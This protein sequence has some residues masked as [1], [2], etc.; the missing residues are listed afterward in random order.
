LE[1]IDERKAHIKAK[2][3]DAI[4][5]SFL[6]DMM[7]RAELAYPSTFADVL[8]DNTTLP[9]HK[10]AKLRQIRCFRMEYEMAQ[11]AKAS[12]LSFTAK[13]LP[14]NDW[15]YTYVVT[16]SFGLTQAYVQQMGLLPNPAKY[17][18][19][20]ANAARIPRLALDDDAAIYES[21]NFYGLIAHNPIGQIF[22]E[23]KQK[24]GSMQLCVPFEGMK[25]WALEIPLPELLS[26]YP[27]V[28]K[29]PIATPEPTW[30]KA[31]IKKASGEK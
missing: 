13:S 19:N 22:E 29:E 3:V 18:E 8:H 23:S 14:E 5:K 12:G 11:A 31:G 15:N 21:R 10:L 9:E 30:K 27:I 26:L 7:R 25:G 16:G 28:T 24:L 2:A 4:P 17:R 20:L 6:L 1:A